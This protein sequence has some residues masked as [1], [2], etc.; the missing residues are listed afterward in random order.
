MWTYNNTD[1]LYHYGVL[2]MRWGVRR[3]QNKDSSLTK[4]NAWKKRRRYT[5]IAEGKLKAEKS[6]NEARRDAINTLNRSSKKHTQFQYEVAAERAARAARKKSI[7]E[8]KEANRQARAEKKTDRDMRK[9]E[10]TVKK[11]STAFQRHLDF[12]ENHRSGNIQ[13]Y[14]TK[15]L[16]KA[17]T[18]GK[19]VDVM[20]NKLS[21]RYARVSAVP[22]KD[23]KTG[24]MYVD[25]ILN[26]KTSRIDVD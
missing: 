8:Q 1:E 5:T 21:K 17:Q 10:D 24:K 11:A 22:E 3:Y 7:I 12:M 2:G 26:D 18:Y 16:K 9:L 15:L 4:T 23:T 6:A 19:D 14:N 20:V 13:I 25:I